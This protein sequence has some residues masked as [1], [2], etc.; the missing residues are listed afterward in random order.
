MKLDERISS[1]MFSLSQVTALLRR[2]R[3]PRHPQSLYDRIRRGTL[4]GIQ[5]HGKWYIPANQ[6]QKLLQEPYH[7]RGG[8]PAIKDTP[9]FIAKSARRRIEI[10]DVAEVVSLVTLQIE[11]RAKLT[12][13]SHVLTRNL[14]RARLE[15]QYPKLSRREISLKVVQE[16]SRHD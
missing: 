11:K 10:P 13:R 5:R 15:S 6:V 12:I 2:A 8:R 9:T 14:I 16:L 7:R 3:K 1:E 4:V